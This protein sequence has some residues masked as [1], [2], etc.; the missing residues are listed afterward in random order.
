MTDVATEDYASEGGATPDEV[1][2]A[3][4]A[5]AEAVLGASVAFRSKDLASASQAD[6]DQ[7]AYLAGAV[8]FTAHQ[9]T[10]AI[11]GDAPPPAPVILSPEERA[12]FSPKARN[13]GRLSGFRRFLK[14]FQSF[15]SG[16]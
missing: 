1:Q 5:M 14:A 15:G 6:L 13:A 11:L 8:V 9:I 12:F 16:Q 4:R 7:L 10:D 3:F 2:R